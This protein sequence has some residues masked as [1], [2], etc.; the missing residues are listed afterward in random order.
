MEASALMAGVSAT[1]AVAASLPAN[2]ILFGLSMNPSSVTASPVYNASAS[3][4]FVFPNATYDYC[5]VTFSYAHK[6]RGD[7][8]NLQ[9]WLPN[10][11]NFQKCFLATGGVAYAINGGISSLPVSVMYGVWYGCR[12]R[13]R[14]LWGI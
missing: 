1:T 3:G 8:V 14:W 12:Y 11:A 10:P 7:N 6:G 9:Y 13:G 5:N 4:Q 2:D